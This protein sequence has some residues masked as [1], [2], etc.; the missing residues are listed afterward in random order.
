M[1]SERNI[2]DWLDVMRERPSMYVRSMIELQAMIH[3]YYNALQHHGITEK[4]PQLSQ[5]HFGTWLREETRWSVCSGWGYAFEQN[6]VAGQDVYES[7][8]SFIDQYR[9]LVPM[10]T[11]SVTLSP[12]HQPTGKRCVIG[13]D[14][15]MDRPD[16]VDVI[17]YYPTSLN[18]FRFHYANR[19]VDEGFLF[20]QTGKQKT[21]HKDL[22]EWMYDEFDVE[23]SEWTIFAGPKDV[24]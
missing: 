23:R 20:L 16:K 6:K 3:G 24:A 21:E 18:H 4:G 13:F 1:I 5:R 8:F 9:R 10:I 22:F 2:F 19:Y 17:N 11:A 15:R 7:F 12:K 14:K